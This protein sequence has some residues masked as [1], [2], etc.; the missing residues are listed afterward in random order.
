VAR[1]EQDGAQEKNRLERRAAR[2]KD[3]AEAENTKQVAQSVATAFRGPPEAARDVGPNM[4]EHAEVKEDSSYVEYQGTQSP[5]TPQ[6]PFAKNLLAM[7]NAR[8]RRIS[9]LFAK[10]YEL[11]S[12]IAAQHPNEAHSEISML[13]LPH[14]KK[15]DGFN[16]IKLS[17]TRNF[18]AVYAKQLHPDVD[19]D[20]VVSAIIRERFLDLVRK[21][22]PRWDLR[23]LP[24]TSGRFSRPGQV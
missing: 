10:N 6:E 22:R 19:L 5:M 4:N 18:A 15:T 17:W 3:N 21:L 14:Q 11:L 8:V 9:F 20:P 1:D 23:H 24:T 7:H 13:P 2:G 12:D 16:G